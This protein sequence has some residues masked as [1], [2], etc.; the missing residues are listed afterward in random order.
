MKSALDKDWRLGTLFNG[1]QL[2]PVKFAERSFYPWCHMLGHEHPITRAVL[3][4]TYIY[5]QIYIYIYM[6]VIPPFKG[7]VG[8]VGK[9]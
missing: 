3:F 6:C 7:G 1:M 8:G 5:I 2:V 9:N 4:Y